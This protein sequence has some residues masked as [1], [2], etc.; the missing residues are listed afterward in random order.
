MASA[1]RTRDHDEIRNWTEQRGGIPTVVKDTEGLLRIDFIRG[2]KSGGR[3]SSLEEVD[4][5]RW[6]EIFDENGLTFLFSP[7]K[8]SRF[9]KLISANPGDQGQRRNRSRGRS[10]HGQHSDAGQT[11]HV[12]VTK[13]NGGWVVELDEDDERKTY[14]TKADAVHHSRELARKHESAEL[15]IE[16]AEGEEEQRVEYGHHN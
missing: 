4:W 3:E 12:V 7:E 9:S 1:K 16:N 11:R 2:A 10:E 6:F 15:I 5:N 14:H 13:E 8:E